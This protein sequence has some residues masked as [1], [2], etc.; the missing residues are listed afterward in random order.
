MKETIW[1]PEDEKIK[2]TDRYVLVR[3]KV[4]GDEAMVSE[5]YTE[6]MEEKDWEIVKI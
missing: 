4:T 5:H 6:L 1:I 2:N 3:N